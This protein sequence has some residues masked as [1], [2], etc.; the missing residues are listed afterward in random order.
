MTPE[1]TRTDPK[2][3][4]YGWIMQVTFITSIVVGAPLVAALSTGV[5]LQTWTERAQFAVGVGSGLW[6]VVAGSLYVYARR[7][8]E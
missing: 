7:N 6:F 5:E 3:I 4:D 2:G 1:V 8:Q